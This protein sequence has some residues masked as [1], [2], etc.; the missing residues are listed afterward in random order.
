MLRDA[1]IKS[2][3]LINVLEKQQE[4]TKHILE[5]D[6][7]PKIDNTTQAQG[8]TIEKLL[9]DIRTINSQLNKVHD[10]VQDHENRIQNVT[11]RLK[12]VEVKTEALSARERVVDPLDQPS[13]KKIGSGGGSPHSP[14]SPRRAS[15]TEGGFG[16]GNGGS[17]A[18]G[19]GGGSGVGKVYAEVMDSIQ[20]QLMNDSLHGGGSMLGNNNKSGSSPLSLLQ[21]GGGS[22][23]MVSPRGGGGGSGGPKQG[24]DSSFSLPTNIT[25]YHLTTN[26]NKIS[27]SSVYK[28]M[29][30][31][32]QFSL[33]PD[34]DETALSLS[35]VIPNSSGGGNHSGGGVGN[36]SRMD[37]NGYFT[38]GT[39]HFSSSSV[40]AA[41]VLIY[42]EDILH[43]DMACEELPV[44]DS[45]CVVFHITVIRTARSTGLIDLSAAGISTSLSSAP[46]QDQPISTLRR[47]TG[48]AAGSV[49]SQ[50]RAN[51]DTEMDPIGSLSSKR[52]NHQHS[53]G[54]ANERDPVKVSLYA[55]VS[56][57]VEEWVQFLNENLGDRVSLGSS[58]L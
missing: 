24:S 28:K 52:G 40:S 48:G 5:G 26:P 30:L 31:G 25:V 39:D 50:L 21:R 22:R 3:E 1:V 37:G 7:I 34:N 16:G 51:Q 2:T 47:H 13:S 19:G 57:T 53:G 32:L 58:L 8:Q 45:D 15:D 27:K 44:D 46:A 29:R 55:P 33:G 18:A 36:M 20:R 38:G 43:V 9:G 49:P 10:Q 12:Q 14:S 35:P 41:T 11:K 4:L 6:L 17:G 42:L 23:S 56:P 54:G